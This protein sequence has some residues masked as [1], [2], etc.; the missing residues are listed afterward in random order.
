M[1][2]RQDKLFKN[3][4]ARTYDYQ[5]E[6]TT[7]ARAAWEACLKANN[8]EGQ[9]HV[10]TPKEGEAVFARSMSTADGLSIVGRVTHY[11]G[12]FLW[13]VVYFNS[14][15]GVWDL[16]DLKPFNASKIGKPWSEI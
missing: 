12:N 2:D 10:W 15:T 3:W 4:Y 13:E 16:K 6:R 9:D 5:D 14:N 8:I 1:N 11:R 7:G